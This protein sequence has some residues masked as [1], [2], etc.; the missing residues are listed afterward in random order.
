MTAREEFRFFDRVLRPI[1]DDPPTAAT[2]YGRKHHMLSAWCAVAFITR[3]GVDE[4]DEP[5]DQRA[6]IKRL[7][8]DQP[9]GGYM[10][11]EIARHVMAIRRLER[12]R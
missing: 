1:T 2:L 5:I 7:L 11:N 12:E 4:N 10:R 8:K 6:A 3:E 9:K